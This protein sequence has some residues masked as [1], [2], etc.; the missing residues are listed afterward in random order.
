M[1]TFHVTAEMA[2]GGVICKLEPAFHGLGVV[3]LHISGHRLSE[4]CGGIVLYWHWGFLLQQQADFDRW[5]KWSPD[6]NKPTRWQHVTTK[7]TAG[8]FATAPPANVDI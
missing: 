3:L 1:L 4:V 5:P 2:S 8:T 7:R 6:F